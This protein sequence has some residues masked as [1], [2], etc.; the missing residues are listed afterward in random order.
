MS[1]IGKSRD[2]FPRWLSGKEPTS[3]CRRYGFDPLLRKI[4][5]EANVSLL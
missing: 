3:Q 2:R 5:G 1:R 4:P